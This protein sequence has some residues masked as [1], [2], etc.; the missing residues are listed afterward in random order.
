MM[1]LKMLLMLMVL[2][3]AASSC[4]TDLPKNDKRS[5]IIKKEDALKVTKLAMRTAALV[6]RH[7]TIPNG[8]SLD[9][10]KQ[11]VCPL[12]S[13]HKIAIKAACMPGF[14][15]PNVDCTFVEKYGCDEVSGVINN[16]VSMRADSLNFAMATTNYVEGNETFGYVKYVGSIS[17]STSADGTRY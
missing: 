5:F 10:A 7:A 4:G 1:K 9:P 15:G 17:A 16:Q 8:A 14:D 12:T 11:P 6:G 13:E 2:A 3:L